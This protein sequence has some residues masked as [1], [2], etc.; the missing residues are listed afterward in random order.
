MKSNKK[1]KKS[2][3]ST[4]SHLLSCV[5][6]EAV[7]ESIEIYL[8]ENESDERKKMTNSLASRYVNEKDDATTDDEN[9]KE[10][11]SGIDRKKI[12]A[13]SD[14]SSDTKDNSQDVTKDI[15]EDSVEVPV[16]TDEELLS[17]S[18]E[19]IRDQL[20]LIRS[21]ASL[22]NRGIDKQFRSYIDSLSEDSTRQLLIYMT[23][24]AQI[25]TG[26]MPA[27]EVIKSG[28]TKS[29]HESQMGTVD[30]DSDSSDVSLAVTDV[31]DD[32]DIMP[33]IVGEHTA[34]RTL[35]DKV[36]SRR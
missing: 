32:N 2:S 31:T 1:T 10:V 15:D 26:K 13:N 20:N 4:L 33:I 22:K 27:S 3:S 9:D 8:N 35:I 7:R 36:K 23:A 19:I 17:P 21:G 12:T 6:S 30:V 24:L 29:S 14:T 18:Y 11:S 16:P 5:T 25:I 28:E 34:V